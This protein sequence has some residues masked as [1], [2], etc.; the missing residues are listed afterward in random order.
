MLSQSRKAA[1]LQK[2]AERTWVA[3]PTDGYRN[4]EKS[5][6]AGNGSKGY[7]FALPP[8]KT[9]TGALPPTGMPA[10]RP[11]MTYVPDKPA[12]GGMFSSFAGLGGIIGSQTTQGRKA[13]GQ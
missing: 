12:S 13:L 10:G 7:G 8:A 5:L 11:G 1:I 2:L 6:Q 3:D 9:A 4:A